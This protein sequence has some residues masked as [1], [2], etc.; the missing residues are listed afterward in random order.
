MSNHTRTNRRSAFIPAVASALLLIAFGAYGLGVTRAPAD[1]KYLASVAAVIDAIPY[2]LGVLV[3]TDIAPTPAAVRL[4]KPNRIFERKYTDPATRANASLLVVHCADV[5]DML[6]HYPPICYPAHG[7]VVETAVTKEVSIGGKPRTVGEYNFFHSGN[8]V[9]R[10][11][12]VLV[13]F[14]VPGGE[15]PIVAD[16][17]ALERAARSPAAAGR[18]AAQIQIVRFYSAGGEQ[19]DLDTNPLFEAIAPVIDTIVRGSS[20]E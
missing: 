8:G 14:V 17:D 18:G 12:T 6:G 13:F 16:M 1:E 5:R 20:H 9:E 10:R 7:W 15:V 4:L 3:G 19:P 11:M 2:R